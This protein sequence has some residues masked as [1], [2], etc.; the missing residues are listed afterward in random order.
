MGT[1]SP[2]AAGILALSLISLTGIPPTAGFVGKLFL[3]NAAINA[4]LVW[5]AVVGVV[6]SVVSAYYYVRVIRVMYMK[7]AESEGRVGVDLPS[8]AALLV[9][10]SAVV[11]LGIFPSSLFDAARTAVAVLQP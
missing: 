11:I 4:D 9:T 6:N 3:F 10:G 1:R 2:W 5:L 7:T 8:A